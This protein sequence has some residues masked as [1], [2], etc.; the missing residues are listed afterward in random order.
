MLITLSII[1]VVAAL[2]IPAVTRS[3]EKATYMAGYKTVYSEISQAVKL[4]MVDNGGSA[5]GLLSV[6]DHEALM[7]L[8]ATKFRTTKICDSSNNVT[9]CWHV[10]GTWKTLEGA[11]P[12]WNYGIGFVTSKGMFIQVFDYHLTCP[13]AK[14]KGL[15]WDDT[16]C[17]LLAVD[18]NGKKGPNRA[19]KDIHRFK[20]FSDGI[21]P[22]DYCSG[23]APL[24][25]CCNINLT[26]GESTGGVLCGYEILNNNYDWEN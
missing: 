9:D 16:E 25:N 17:A 10:A 26:P 12:A 20:M 11:D 2:T 7:N 23:G 15:P 13:M 19:G 4:L 8:V 21:I 14:D 5:S 18:L 6:L 22:Y 24:A 1:G 3:Y